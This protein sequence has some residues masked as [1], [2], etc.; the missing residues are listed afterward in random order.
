MEP[1]IVIF[2]CKGNTLQYQ[3]EW[4]YGA[5]PARTKGPF[6]DPHAHMTLNS[7]WPTQ[8]A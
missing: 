6:N 1:I 7:Y 4:K 8:I 3:S 2:A 5:Q